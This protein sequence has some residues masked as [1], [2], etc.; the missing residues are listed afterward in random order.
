MRKQV[1]DA[2]IFGIQGFCKDLLEVA[3][4]LHLAVI[5][6]DVNKLNKN[7]D[8]SPDEQ[9]GFAKEQVKSIFDGLVMTEQKLIK[10][11]AKHGLDRIVPTEGE[12]FDPNIH[13]AIFQ[14]KIPDKESGTIC[15][16]NQIGYKLKERVIRAAHVGVAQ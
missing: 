9:L 16:V 8:K 11:F 3:D 1:D 14:A 13:E 12:K 5:N 2:K 10:I 15:N 7:S 6:T 4:T